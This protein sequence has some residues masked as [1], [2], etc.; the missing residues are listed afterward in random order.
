MI[1]EEM[2]DL[3]T[4]HE[5]DFGGELLDTLLATHINLL[6]LS[7]GSQTIRSLVASNSL[8]VFFP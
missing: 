3:T 7:S 1:E 6:L 5:S 2:K 4:S 8:Y